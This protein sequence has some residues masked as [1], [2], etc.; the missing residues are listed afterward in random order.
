[1]GDHNV[2]GIGDSLGPPASSSPRDERRRSDEFIYFAS[3][4]SFNSLFLTGDPFNQYADVVAYVQP[5]SDIR[6]P[7]VPRT[8][9]QTSFFDV[10]SPCGREPQSKNTWSQRELHTPVGR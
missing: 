2:V 7:I 4:G 1:M 3:K 5:P 6:A 9:D 8:P 10:Y